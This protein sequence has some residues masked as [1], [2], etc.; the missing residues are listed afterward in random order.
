MKKAACCERRVI[1][2]S[3]LHR[4]FRIKMMMTLRWSVLL[5]SP[6]TKTLRK[7]EIKRLELFFFYL[8]YLSSIY[9]KANCVA[10]YWAGRPHSLMSC[11]F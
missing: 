10:I 5:Y 3:S 8:P 6:E 1:L 9:E 11:H 7:A 4:T 2:G